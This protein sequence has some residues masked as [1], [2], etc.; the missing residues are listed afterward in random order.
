MMIAKVKYQIGTYSGEVD[1]NCNQ[2]DEDEFIIA[3]AKR[4]LRQRAGGAFLV[5]MGVELW[6]VLERETI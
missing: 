1:V 4:V 3:K 5:P 6:V 2:A